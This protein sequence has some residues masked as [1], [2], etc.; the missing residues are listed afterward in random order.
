M[1]KLNISRSHRLFER[2]DTIV[3]V[4]VALMVIS[5]VLAS[6][7]VLTNRTTRNVRDAEEHSQAA[8]L[9][10]GQ[11]ES[12]RGVAHTTSYGLLPSFFCFA[13]DGTITTLSGPT[14]Y[15]CNAGTFYNFVIAKGSAPSAAG[16]TTKFVLKTQWS[17][18][19]GNNAVETF[20]YKVTLLP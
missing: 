9:L 16:D 18:V 15:G 8:Q 1:S 13:N 3:E 17:S 12:L 11:L 6:A 20:V 14:S 2:G 4:M 10:Q 19:T 7:F 5:S